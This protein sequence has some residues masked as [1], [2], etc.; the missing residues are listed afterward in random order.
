MPIK[1][2]ATEHTKA[3]AKKQE[4][5]DQVLD[6]M[7]THPGSTI[8]NHASEIILHIHSDASYLSVSHARSHLVGHF[9]C[10]DKPPNEENLNR[11][12]LNVE[13]FIKNVVASAAEPEVGVFFQNAQIG[14]P[15]RI[16]LIELGHKQPATLPL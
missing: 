10:G 6:Y 16:T 11:S 5:T 7:V 8:R 3:T 14:A 9:F 15:I 12:L 1:D 2:I 13:A 4:A